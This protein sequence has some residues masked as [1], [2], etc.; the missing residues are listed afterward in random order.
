MS[1]FF[2]L[3]N[4]TTTVIPKKRKAKLMKKNSDNKKPEIM[5]PAGDWTALRAAIEAGCDSIY[6]GIKGI[7]MRAGA[8]NF[9][10]SDMKKITR[11]CQ[12]NGVK[13][14]LALNTVVYES[15]IA[16]IKKIILKGKEAGVD[17]IICW[18]FAVIQ[19]AT[20]Q[21]IPVCISTQMSVS[22]SSSILFFYKN[23]GIK[24][25]VLARD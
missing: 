11:H 23:F 1:I 17:T 4:Q 2:F 9:P 5:S 24:R 7:N 12:K 20:K 15:D 8:E 19:E 25:Y 21:G 22:N 14:Y 3:S 6:F 10:P 13:A 16:N 18:D